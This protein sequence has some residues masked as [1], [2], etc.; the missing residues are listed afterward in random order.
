MKLTIPD[1]TK[2]YTI[3]EW[4]IFFEVGERVSL[5]DLQKVFTLPAIAELISNDK[6]TRDCHI[7]VPK[8]DKKISRD[9]QEGKYVKASDDLLEWV[10]VEFIQMHG[11]KYQCRILANSYIAHFKFIK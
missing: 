5:S 7:I 8:G 11:E 2:D 1:P 3:N 9:H 10:D 4:L 6:V